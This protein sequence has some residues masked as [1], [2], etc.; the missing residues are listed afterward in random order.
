MDEPFKIMFHFRGWLNSHIVN[1]DLN[2][3]NFDNSD[4]VVS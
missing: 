4:T 2:I 3:V 1:S